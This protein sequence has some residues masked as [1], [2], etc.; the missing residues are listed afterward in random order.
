MVE[1]LLSV[2][3]ALLEIPISLIGE[4]VV[5]YKSLH[6]VGLTKKESRNLGPND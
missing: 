3:D 2:L 6:R 4:E 5:E 1:S